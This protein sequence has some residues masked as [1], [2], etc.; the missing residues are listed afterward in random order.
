MLMV[1]QIS[2]TGLPVQS[3]LVKYSACCQLWSIPI[4]STLQNVIHH[5]LSKTFSN[6]CQCPCFTHFICHHHH[7]L[8]ATFYRVYI[9]IWHKSGC[10]GEFPCLTNF[11]V[12]V[13][14]ACQNSQIQANSFVSCTS[15]CKMSLMSCVHVCAGQSLLILP[16]AGQK[17][18]IFQMDCDGSIFCKGPII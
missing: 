13:T 5:S 11:I 9:L 6:S 8:S 15:M 14:T 3:S 7:S 12:N 2:G 4:V 16:G 18:R 10:S 1:V 17:L